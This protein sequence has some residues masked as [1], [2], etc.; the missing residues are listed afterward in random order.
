MAKGTNGFQG[1]FSLLFLAVFCWG[2]R[3]RFSYFGAKFRPK[4][5]LFSSKTR[6]FDPKRVPNTTF[7]TFSMG[8]DRK[9]PFSSETGRFF[10]GRSKKWYIGPVFLSKIWARLRNSGSKP[11]KVPVS[12]RNFAFSGRN[13]VENGSNSDILGRIQKSGRNFPDRVP[14]FPESLKKV[15]LGTTISGSVSSFLF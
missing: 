3:K 2:P 13:F 12:G 11:K 5:A 4:T 15:V 14:L 6:N 10:P 9:R 1:F 8:P 7:F